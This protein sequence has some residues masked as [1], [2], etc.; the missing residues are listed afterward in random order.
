MEGPMLGFSLKYLDS[1]RMVLEDWWE[2]YEE[3]EAFEYWEEDV[4]ED[5]LYF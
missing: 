4:G 1:E 2:E 3:V 5:P